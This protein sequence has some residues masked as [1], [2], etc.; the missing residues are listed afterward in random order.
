MFVAKPVHISLL[1]LLVIYV[2]DYSHNTVKL[3]AP[4]DTNFG[5]DPRAITCNRSDHAHVFATLNA[6][7]VATET[8]FCQQ[9]AT[10]I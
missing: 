6:P 2:L 10:R 7:G 8:A 1:Y 4:S 9:T 3:N 5:S